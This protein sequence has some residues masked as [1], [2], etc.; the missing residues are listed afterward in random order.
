[1]LELTDDLFHYVPGA[2]HGWVLGLVLVDEVFIH[3]GLI[4]GVQVICVSTRVDSDAL[5]LAGSRGRLQNR[6]PFAANP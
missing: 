3:P 2:Y 4:T 5:V 1:M 6:P